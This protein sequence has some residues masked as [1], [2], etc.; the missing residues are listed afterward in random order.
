MDSRMRPLA[1][2]HN[3]AYDAVVGADSTRSRS[4]VRSPPLMTA[5]RG[6]T[7]GEFDKVDHLLETLGFKGSSSHIG[8]SPRSSNRN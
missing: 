7:P 6:V 8:L 3:P 1:Y 5:V 4:S 2:K